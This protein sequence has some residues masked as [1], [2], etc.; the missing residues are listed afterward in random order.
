MR[1]TVLALITSLLVAPTDPRMYTVVVALPATLVIL[2]PALPLFLI[3][4]LVEG[5]RRGEVPIDV[6]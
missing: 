4:R 3:M 5:R 6:Y 1:I 2:I